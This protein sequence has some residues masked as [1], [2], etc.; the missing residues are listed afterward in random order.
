MLSSLPCL[1]LPLR[2]AEAVSMGFNSREPLRATPPPAPAQTGKTIWTNLF[3]EAMGG[4]AMLILG[5]VAWLVVT[6]PAQL[7]EIQF[8]QK[9]AIENMKKI[10]EVQERHESWLREHERRLI[11]E[12][13]LSR[14]GK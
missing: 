5:G 2:K 12:E 10:I 14:G 9:S 7:N 4:V 3:G 8:N 11:R 1:T 13:T 6:L